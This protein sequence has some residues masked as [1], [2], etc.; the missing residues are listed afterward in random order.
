[1]S[2]ARESLLWI[3]PEEYLEA[4]K[5]ADVKH[6]YV[7]GRV[8]AMSAASVDH[9]RISGNLR[10]ELHHQL[11]GKKCEPFGS[12][13]KV[14]IPPTLPNCELTYY[15]PDVQVACQP[16]MERDAYFREYPAVIF[17]VISPSTKATDL[18]EK[19]AAYLRIDSL[20]HYCIVEQER[21]EVTVYRRVGRN[22][23][24]MRWTQPEDVIYLGGIGCELTLEQI[25]ER[26][27]WRS[28]A[29]L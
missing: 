29:A 17:E 28:A 18:R 13:M 24:I 10:G 14:K 11:R 20:Q 19:R 26:V 7:E 12:D 4:E 3:G 22:W 6:E 25:Y 2:V 16:E 15:Y 23:E 5:V 27:S 9:E 8:F 21:M 1:M